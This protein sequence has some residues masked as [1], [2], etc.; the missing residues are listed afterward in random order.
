M[1]WQVCS[2][3]VMHVLVVNSVA[4]VAMSTSQEIQSAEN[5]KPNVP[6]KSFQLETGSVQSKLQS[7]REFVLSKCELP[8]I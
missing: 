1:Q 3:S 7:K 2:S 6:H 4:G 8:V 5:V